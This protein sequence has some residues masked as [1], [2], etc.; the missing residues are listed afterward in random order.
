M[1][2]PSSSQWILNTLEDKGGTDLIGTLKSIRASAEPMLSRICNT[3]GDY[4]VHDVRHSDKICEILGWLLPPH[5]LSEMSEYEV[6]FIAASAYLHDIGMADIPRVF[7]DSMFYEW[8]KREGRTGSSSDARRDFIREFHHKRSERFVNES[9]RELGIPNKMEAFI[10]GRICRGHRNLD[11]LKDFKLYPRKFVYHGSVNICSLAYFLQIADEIDI[12]FSRAP[13]IIYENFKPKN[14]ISLVEWEKSLSISDLHLDPS[15]ERAIIGSALCQS[16]KVH[17]ALVLYETKVQRKLDAA[18]QLL[19]SS[20]SRLFPNRIKMQITATGYDYLDLEFGFDFEAIVPLLTYRIYSRP[21]DAIREL[22]QNAIDACHYRAD[23]YKKSTRVYEPKVSFRTFSEDDDGF[24]EVEDNGVGMDQRSI[25]FYFARIGR[26]FYR[27]TEFLDHI[28]S[29]L[30]ISEFGL[31][32]LSVFMIASKVQIE[33]KTDDSQA[34]LLEIFPNDEHIFV[35]KGNRKTTGTR[36]KLWLRKDAEIDILSELIFYARHIDFPITVDTNGRIVEINQKWRTYEDFLGPNAPNVLSKYAKPYTFYLESARY[37]GL[38]SFPSREDKELG[39][40]PCGATDIEST[41]QGNLIAISNRGIFVEY[42]DVFEFSKK[43][44]LCAAIDLNILAAPVSLL[45]GRNAIKRDPQF[46]QLMNDVICDLIP[47][48]TVLLDGYLKD[49]RVSTTKLQDIMSSIF[50]LFVFNSLP[51]ELQALVYRYVLLRALKDGTV[52][53]I[54]LSDVREG[55]DMFVTGLPHCNEREITE[56]LNSL[57]FDV[58]EGEPASALSARFLSKDSMIEK[59]AQPLAMH[60]EPIVGPKRLTNVNQRAFILLRDEN[61]LQ[62]IMSPERLA[63]DSIE[64]GNLVLCES[65]CPSIRTS[66][67][68][69]RRAPTPSLPRGRFERYDLLIHFVHFR[70]VTTRRFAI[71]L[72]PAQTDY[73]QLEKGFSGK[74]S[75]PTEIEVLVVPLFVNMDSAF[76]DAMLRVF[77]EAFREEMMPIFQALRTRDFNEVQKI[78]QAILGKMSNQGFTCTEEMKFRKE[79]FPSFL[80]RATS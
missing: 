29:F 4:T 21:Q 42:L 46:V 35:A 23:I 63:A 24:L 30:P 66:S 60:S 36:V 67:D 22:L 41:G 15:D 54:R 78:Q 72:E 62:D 61:I 39:T 49:S 16:E 50:N 20:Q 77:G 12:N 43:T 65:S 37:Q 45:L 79:D 6:F 58:T 57:R 47:Q 19:D 31:G 69:R 11:E 5:V 73:I 26:S 80:I 33:T 55:C 9:F 38:I 32:I 13:L 64:L 70:N 27:S 52:G 71:A 75:R 53:T 40:I 34:Y 51:K 14:P 74:S 56:L 1:E 18:D 10:L 17:R 59:K 8:L 28:P 25:A 76:A 7:D 68:L 3:F 48:L 44:G 2:W